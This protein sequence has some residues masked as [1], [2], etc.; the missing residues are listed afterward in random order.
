MGLRT[1]SRSPKPTDNIPTV[2]SS[3]TSKKANGTTDKNISC[4][5]C[6]PASS[7]S[8]DSTSCLTNTPNIHINSIYVY[9][10][11]QDQQMGKNGSP[12]STTRF[13]SPASSGGPICRICH[14]G[15]GREELVSPCRCAGT[16][17]VVHK[18]CM[19]RWLSTR[20][21]P[22]DKCEICN[23][24]FVTARSPKSIIEWIRSEEND[25]NHRRS[26]VGDVTCFILLTPLAIVSSYLCVEGAK[27]QVIWGNSL[28]AGCLMALA[29]FLITIYFVWNVLTI[30]YHLKAY[31]IWRSR[32]QNVKLLRVQ[33]VS[34]AAETST[35]L[36]EVEAVP[37]ETF[38]STSPSVV[39]RIPDH[40][41]LHRF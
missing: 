39:I 31:C 19:E 9:N 36:E 27:K 30:R 40:P 18:T 29:T 21:N 13:Q 12:F 5:N 33:R 24:A 32:N 20:C 38:D 23:Y 35:N 34:T 15:D 25:G 3:D 1:E 11:S 37:P 6:T 16:V 4:D 7:N 8:V 28:E 14:E 22:N 10:F 41:D 26:L 17:G 2:H